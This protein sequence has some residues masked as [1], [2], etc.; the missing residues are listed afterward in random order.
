MGTH[1]EAWNGPLELWHDNPG[2]YFSRFVS[3]FCAPS[4]AFL[5]GTGMVLLSLSR[6]EKLGWSGMKL[7]KFFWLRGVVLVALGFVVR[8]AFWVELINPSER[9][10]LLP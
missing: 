9:Y 4:F 5:M 8:M 6:R 3:H 2:Y 7:F 1:S 10:D